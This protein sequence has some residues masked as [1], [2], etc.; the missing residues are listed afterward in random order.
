[1]LFTV[2]DRT[3]LEPKS[4][5]ETAWEF[6]DRSAWPEIERARAFL[7]NA[8]ANYPEHERAELI[9]RFSSNNDQ[10]FRSATFEVI[11]FTVFCAL[12]CKI[13]AHPELPS[14]NRSRPD[15]LVVTPDGHSLYVEAVFASERRAKDAAA[16][17]RTNVVLQS[18]EKVDSPNFFLGFHSEGD[19]D[20]PPNGRKLRRAVEEWLVTLDPDQ[21]TAELDLFGA[22]RIPEM[23][24]KS[25]DWTVSIEAH[26]KKPDRRGK[27]QST[28]GII[29]T[30]AGW[31]N[32]SEPI[33]DA[34]CE[35]GNKYGELQYPLMI[36]VNVDT[37]VLEQIDEM[38]ALFGQEQVVFGSD[39]PEEEPR[40]TYAPNGAW[41]GPNGP[42]YTRISGAWL[43][44][45]LSLTNMT[46][47]KQT[48][49]FHPNAQRPLPNFFRI[50]PHAG[51]EGAKMIW[52]D[53]VSFIDV[54]GLHPN[55]P[56]D[57]QD[58]G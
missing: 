57:P 47:R 39:D 58:V 29:S 21:V 36:A 17:K 14:G 40:L 41:N 11:L 8:I 2:K 23:Q 43:F 52:Q 1:M 10:H 54:L 31:R 6:Y 22:Y 32:V 7:D 9:A 15:F 44:H 46:R 49:Y 25:G 3:S 16:E 27:G 42:Q 45:D 37:P 18:L 30:G 33:R 28:V 53:G 5:V 51:T 34:I 12:G 26:V 4:H 24:W 55:W 35:K 13:D 20:H 56:H 19:P 50:F 38:Q 48:V